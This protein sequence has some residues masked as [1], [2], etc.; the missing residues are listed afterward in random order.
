MCRRP[1]LRR[2]ADLRERQDA[3][4]RFDREPDQERAGLDLD[5]TH[6]RELE[7]DPRLRHSPHHPE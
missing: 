1:H 4:L 6:L 7:D 5:D 3:G 2:L